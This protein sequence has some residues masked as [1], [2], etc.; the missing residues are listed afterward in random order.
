MLRSRGVGS[1]A[2]VGLVRWLGSDARP[3]FRMRRRRTD[4]NGR[5]QLLLKS[6]PGGMGTRAWFGANVNLCSPIHTPS[7]S[8]VPV[9]LLPPNLTSCTHTPTTHTPTKLQCPKPLLD[10]FTNFPETN[11]ISNAVF[12]DDCNVIDASIRW[13]TNHCHHMIGCVFLCV[14]HLPPKKVY[15]IPHSY[16]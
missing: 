5:P 11:L 1:G 10:R 2:R 12:T 7:C 14:H 13:M 15:D 8:N 9:C 4:G 3:F 6:H 16:L